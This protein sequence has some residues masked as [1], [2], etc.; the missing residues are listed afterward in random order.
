M[1]NFIFTYRHPA[2][3]LP[4][5]VTENGGQRRAEV[6]NDPQAVWG[7]YFDR[8]GPSVIDPGQPVFERTSV[9]QIGDSTKLGGYSVIKADD[10]AA[11]VALAKECPTVRLGGGVEVGLLVELPADHPAALLKHH[12]V[13]G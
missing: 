5:G 11:A 7:A 8:I 2:N 9:G 10:L 6:D 3:Y 4:G 12:P 1:P 13:A